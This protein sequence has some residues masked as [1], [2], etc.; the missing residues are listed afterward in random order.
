MQTQY[1]KNKTYHLILLIYYQLILFIEN[2]IARR[3]IFRGRR[4][5]TIHNCTMDVDSG[6][7]DNDKFR[8][9]FQWY[10]MKSKD[11]ISSIKHKSKN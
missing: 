5:G 3:L 6:Y 4:S 9:C 7:K 8:G 1:M 11:S 10:M 2:D